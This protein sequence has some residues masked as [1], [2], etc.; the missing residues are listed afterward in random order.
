MEQMENNSKSEYAEY[1]PE[2]QTTETRYPVTDPRKPFVCQHC[3]IGF[4]R[5][6][7]M[8]SHTRVHAEGDSP[9]ECQKCGEMFWDPAQMRE[10]AKLK[11]GD[12]ED[13]D[14]DEDEDYSEEETKYGT[15]YCTTCGLSFHRQDNLRRH[16]RVHIKEE[17]VNE[18]EFGH[19]CNVCGESFQE[20]L[21][22]LAH[23]EV[24]ARG[25]EHRCMICG[26]SGADENAV[27]VHV[28]VNQSLYLDWN[29]I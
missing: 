10:H 16:Q 7:A 21:D 22:L 18:H 12:V 23:A 1:I 2:D 5:E 3:G 4:A 27:A 13:F 24:H 6:K 15:Y 26:E 19:I 29:N 20:A 8:L 25:T 11:H 14:D 28:Q 9:F 17:F